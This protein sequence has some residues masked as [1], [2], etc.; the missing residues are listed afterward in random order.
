MTSQTSD[1]VRKKSSMGMLLGREMSEEMAWIV[2]ER[3]TPMG[4]R[5]KALRRAAS[6]LS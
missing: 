3:M 4:M 1:R 5:R 6:G 2:K